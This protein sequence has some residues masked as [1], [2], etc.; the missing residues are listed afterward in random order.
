M[1]RHHRLPLGA[2]YLGDG[3]TRFILWGP[4]AERVWMDLEN[5]DTTHIQRG[6]ESIFSATG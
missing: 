4:A 1:R 6:G 5:G 2:E 3:Q